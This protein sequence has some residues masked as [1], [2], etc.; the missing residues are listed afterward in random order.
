MTTAQV[1][2]LFG[3]CKIRMWVKPS[4]PTIPTPGTGIE[5]EVPTLFSMVFHC[6]EVFCGDV[7]DVAVTGTWRGCPMAQCFPI[8]TYKDM[9]FYALA[10]SCPSLSVISDNYC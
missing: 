1:I 5:L 7:A 10:S 9:I 6:E 2:N 3:F 8:P 4:D